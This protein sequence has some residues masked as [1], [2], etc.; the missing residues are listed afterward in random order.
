M[1][2]TTLFKAIKASTFQTFR[3]QT[4]S[5]EH[6]ENG[7]VTFTVLESVEVILKDQPIQLY[8]S[9]IHI[10]EPTRPY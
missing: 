10:S 7:E 5:L 9:L 4:L 1:I 2:E 8:L 6:K 3:D